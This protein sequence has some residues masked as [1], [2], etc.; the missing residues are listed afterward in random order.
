MAV[1]LCGR[2][3]LWKSH[4]GCS[5]RRNFATRTVRTVWKRPILSARWEGGGH[6]EILC[7]FPP[8]CS[9]S[10]C[11]SG[12][13]IQTSRISSFHTG[14]LIRDM[15]E[16][17]ILRGWWIIKVNKMTTLYKWSLTVAISNFRTYP[18][19]MTL[20]KQQHFHLEFSVY[21]TCLYSLCSLL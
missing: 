2:W 1:A 17:R 3:D 19:Q 21:G 20:Q 6:T 15:I 14:S 12:K 8:L 13:L 7:F 16:S 5:P 18:S 11:Q 4:C 10:V 9:L